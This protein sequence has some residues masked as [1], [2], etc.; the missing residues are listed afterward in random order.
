MAGMAPRPNGGGTG[1]GLGQRQA[2]RGLASLG[3]FPQV[4]VL[5]AKNIRSPGNLERRFSAGSTLKTG[6]PRFPVKTRLPSL[7]AS[8]AGG[9]IIY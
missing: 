5:P 4:Q 3:R 2:R 9:G 6:T 8:R 1:P 7:D